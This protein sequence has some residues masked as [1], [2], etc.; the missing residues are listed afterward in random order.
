MPQRKTG[1]GRKSRGQTRPIPP[2]LWATFITMAGLLAW[3]M[4][5]PVAPFIWLAMLIGGA[6]AQYPQSSTGRK[7]DEPD[8]KKL[9][10]YHK[11]KNLQK[12]LVPGKRWLEIWRISWWVGVFIALP[13][14]AN[15]IHPLLILANVLFAFMAVQAQTYSR[16]RRKDHRH[17]YQG[18]S[19]PAFMAKAPMWQKVTAISVGVVALLVLGVLWLLLYIPGVMA[20]SVP[21][22]TFLSVVT[23]MDRP[24]QSGSWRQVVVWQET[25]DRWIKDSP[26]EKAW[27]DAYVSQVNMFGPEENQMTVLRVRLPHGV[28]EAMKAGVSRVKPEAIQ[29]GYN[30]VCLLYA[31]SR[32]TGKEM[33]SPNSLR[34]VVGKTEACIP[35]ITA[36]SCGEKVAGLVADIAYAQC[37]L[38]WKKT[39]PLV[40]AHDVSADEEKAAWLLEF[41]MPQTGGTSAENIGIDWLAYETNPG[42]YM[43]L[44]VVNDVDSAFEFAGLPDTP[45]SDAGN[46]WR[47]P[48]IITSDTSFDRYMRLSG[49]FREEQRIWTTA[50]QKK[51]PAPTPNYDE[52]TTE[53]GDGWVLD[54]LPLSIPAPYT[55]ADYARYDLRTLSPDARFVGV[56]P[57]SRGMMLVTAT[58][59]APGGMGELLGTKRNQ[60]LYAAAILFKALC[61]ALPPHG[62][63]SLG[64][65]TQEGKDVAI[66]RAIV[67]TGNGA[68]IADLR[69]KTGGLLVDTG[70]KYIL[71]D[72][73]S[74]SN[75]TIWLMDHLYTDITDIPHFKHPSRQRDLLLL[76]LSNAWGTAGVKDSTGQTPR[77]V[78]LSTFPRNKQVLKARFCIPSGLSMMNIEANQEKFLVAAGYRYGRILPRSDEHGADLW[79]MALCA[80]TPFPNMVPA[81]W[82]YV[83]S[84]NDRVFPL[85]VD[86]MGELVT[87][88]LRSTYHIAVMGKSGTGKSSAAQIVVAD[89]FLHG[90]DVIII[91]PSKGAI[92]FTTWAK[93]RA[94]AFVGNGQLLETEAAIMWAW[95]EMRKRVSLLSEYGAK[96]IYELPDDAR[97]TPIV[98]VFD[99][100]NGYL[101][102]KGKASPNPDRD[103]RIANKN[104]EINNINNSLRRTMDNLS[105]IATQG[106][107][108]G[109]HLVLGAQRLSVK[110]FDA[111]GKGAFWKTLGR[112]LLGSDTPEGVIDPKNITEAHRLQKSMKGKG[113]AIPRGRALWE[114]MEGSLTA[115][116]TWYSGG[117]EA[118]DQLLADIPYREPIDLAPYMPAQAQQFGLIQNSDDIPESADETEETVTQSMLD[119]AEVIDLGDWTI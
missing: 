96:D 93:P 59:N 24:R 28:E 52:E 66:W 69:K 72:W 55:V 49:R 111:Y 8:P 62:T 95:T 18:V 3:Y 63:V 22:L 25:L 115:V 90:Y 99:E 23:I 91:D 4:G 104:A 98:I 64:A 50:L 1:Y 109:V 48:D 77:V 37:A 61:N 67:D 107:T 43:R 112:V 16:D 65:C 29:D 27:G 5:L 6:T 44:P 54:L 83:R 53:T 84:V 71:W 2:G 97:P 106:R 36:R 21:A 76:A 17:P 74:P 75:A 80:V 41:T 101:N 60:R 88:D 58:G 105:D 15:L 117:A 118:L 47:H 73:R 92:D 39:P 79:D 100:F 10:S 68:T 34:L 85:G 89:A 78:E 94:L 42:T 33:F 110:D 13:F 116:Q 103:I 14:S 11:W 45:L 81:D 32:K 30:F 102:N 119:N 12:G 114:T 20:L 40:K 70:V 35:D 57:N 31:R 56:A 38:I 9:A 87:W 7:T 82:D 113:G 51:L 46:K 19:I 108:A 86:D 26:M